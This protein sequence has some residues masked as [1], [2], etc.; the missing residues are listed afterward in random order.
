V[1]I[2]EKKR[3]EIPLG[4]INQKKRKKKGGKAMLIRTRLR[5]RKKRKIN[6]KKQ[7]KCG[8]YAVQK[9]KKKV[10]KANHVV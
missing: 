8:D 6:N 3:R 7:I 4:C 5:R 9:E 2:R 10:I 1:I